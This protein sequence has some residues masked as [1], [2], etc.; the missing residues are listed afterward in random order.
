[1][2]YGSL[3]SGGP[4]CGDCPAEGVADLLEP[5][6]FRST[7]RRGTTV[8]VGLLPARGAGLL[9]KFDALMGQEGSRPTTSEN[10]QEEDEQ[11]HA[12]R[13]A[14]GLVKYIDQPTI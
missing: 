4:E 2:K 14:H 12:Q 3:W 9:T 13:R 11:S 6:R 8:T 7:G 1:M 10:A 5:A